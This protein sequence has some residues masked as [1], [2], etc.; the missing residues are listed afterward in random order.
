[1]ITNTRL[2]NFRS[3]QDES[4]EFGSGV[5]IIVGPNG[6]G[7]TNLLE[8]ILVLCSGS[9]YRVADAE[10]IRFSAEWARLDADLGPEHR[11]VKLQQDNGRVKKTYEFDNKAY[12][13]LTFNHTHPVVLFEP[14]H[15]QLLHGQPEHR[16]IYLD[17]LLEQTIPTYKTTLRHYR[18]VLAQRNALLKGMRPP[19]KEQLFVWNL[20]LSELGGVI[21]KARH[22]LTKEVNRDLPAVYAAI[23][24]T[25]GYDVAVSYVSKLPLNQYETALLQALD[26]SYETDKARGFTSYGPHRDDFLVTFDKHPVQEV[27]S[28]GETRT[29]LL[30]FKIHE[31]KMLEERR[32]KKPI[33]LLDDV[34]SELDGKRRHSL[35]EHLQQYQTFITT[36]DADVVVQTFLEKC[37]IIPLGG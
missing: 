20:R 35:T 17:N 16:R 4:F 25:E 37:T 29:V 3:Y 11:V 18:R 1:M 9:S 31:L 36:T 5:N 15:L 7:K 32:D 23:A 12:K 28:R 10:L 19:T 2:Q 8:A 22:D 14:N 6:S 24:G 27:A 21:A 30:A 13:L 26:K 33:L 34:F